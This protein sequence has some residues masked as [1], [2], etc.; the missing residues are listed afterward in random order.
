MFI[1]LRANARGQLLSTLGGWLLSRESGI[2]KLAAFHL[3]VHSKRLPA[4]SAEIM[5]CKKVTL[6]SETSSTSS[7]YAGEERRL[8]SA[9]NVSHAGL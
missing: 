6:M 1:K 2:A 7:S 9:H 4:T 5:T 3:G 8:K